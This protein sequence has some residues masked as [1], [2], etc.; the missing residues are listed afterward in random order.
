MDLNS[1]GVGYLGSL[2]LDL[3]ELLDYPAIRVVQNAFQA[4]SIRFMLRNRA[5]VCLFPVQLT[6]HWLVVEPGCICRVGVRC[7]EEE[8]ERGRWSGETLTG[9]CLPPPGPT[10]DWLYRDESPPWIF[11]L[12]FFSE[13]H[14]VHFCTSDSGSFPGRFDHHILSK[15]S[16]VYTL[17]LH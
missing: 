15:Q 12:T 2:V 4:A 14:A 7:T 1:P 10:V 17:L 13:H 11:H 6:W 8:G 5:S 3:L 9:R 16:L